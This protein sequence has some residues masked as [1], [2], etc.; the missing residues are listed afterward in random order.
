MSAKAEGLGA[1]H[2][3]SPRDKDR[4][5]NQRFE[6]LPLTYVPVFDH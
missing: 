5:C 3:W 2:R 1:P 4:V 6:T